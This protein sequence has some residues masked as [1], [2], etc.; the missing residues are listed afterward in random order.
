MPNP[1]PTDFKTCPC[2]GELFE[3]FM[4]IGGRNPYAFKPTMEC[5]K[6][7]DLWETKEQ[8]EKRKGIK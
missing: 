3:T 5:K 1:K 8:Y 2:G 4:E 6:C 7:G